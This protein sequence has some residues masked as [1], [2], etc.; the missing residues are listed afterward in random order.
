MTQNTYYL[1]LFPGAIGP[2]VWLL[3]LTFSTIAILKVNNT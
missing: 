1:P 3:V 2:F